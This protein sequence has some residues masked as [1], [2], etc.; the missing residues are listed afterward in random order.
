MKGYVATG[1]SRPRR[2]PTLGRRYVVTLIVTLL[3]GVLMA[4]TQLRAYAVSHGAGFSSSESIRL[5]V[6]IGLPTTGLARNLEGA[7]GAGFWYA[8]RDRLVIVATE[9]DPLPDGIP[10]DFELR[11]NYPN[12]F[13]PTTRIRYGVPQTSFVRV[14]VFNVLGQLVSELVSEEKMAGYYDIDWDGRDRSGSQLPSGLYFYRLH[15]GQFTATRSMIL[16]K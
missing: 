14:G 6:T 16:Q 12:P 5:G 9:S 2:Q 7:G 4:Q 11:A 3:P 10:E 1:S 13:N 15:A 8:T